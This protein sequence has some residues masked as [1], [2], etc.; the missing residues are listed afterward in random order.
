V[1]IVN[2]CLDE[3]AM[4]SLGNAV[5]WDLEILRHVQECSSCGN[6]LRELG[7]IRLA[8]SEQL[9]PGSDFASA[10][11]RN[12][13]VS[14]SGA[15]RHLVFGLNLVATSLLAGLT[16]FFAA[17]LATQTG[18]ASALGVP[19]VVVALGVTVGTLA[20]NVSHIRRQKSAA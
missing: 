9:N 11:L 16:T 18:E 6:R 17:A 7:K 13:P 1:D 12:L 19:M 10:V 14:D 2:E 15:T 5:D 8:L 20:W 4:V 3:D